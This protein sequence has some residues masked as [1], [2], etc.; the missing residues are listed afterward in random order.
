MLR[1]TIVNAIAIIGGSMAGM[2]LTWVAHHFSNHL[3]KNSAD[4]GNRLQ[5]IIMQGLALCTLYIGI[6]GSLKGQNTLVAIISMALGAL[7]GELLALDDAIHNLGD[8][9]QAKMQHLT[10]NGNSSISEG[11]VTASLLYCVGAMAIVG[12]LDS[13]LVNDHSTLY[14]KSLLDGISAIVFAAT[15]GVGV[16]LS[17]GAVFLYQGVIAVAAS[18]LAPLLTEAVITEMSCVGSLLI[19]AISTNM[20]KITKINVMNLVPAIFLPMILCRFM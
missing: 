16:T 9:V 4:L 2:L 5:E 6:S 14:A 11:F 18:Y 10:R 20:L 12:S 8:W 19:I 13:G 1:G 17:A 15:L 7:I 3:P